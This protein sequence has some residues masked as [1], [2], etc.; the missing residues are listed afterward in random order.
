MNY[1]KPVSHEMKQNDG[2]QMW[3]RL[4]GVDWLVSYG[5]ENMKTKSWMVFDYDAGCEFF[6]TEEEAKD[7]AEALLDSYRED[8]CD[9]WDEG[10]EQ[11][12]VAKVTGKIS[13]PI[14]TEIKKGD[15]HYGGEFDF[16]R[17]YKFVTV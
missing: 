3:K 12:V 2:H 4:R 8:A 1:L 14:D 5:G 6:E 15:M 7:H 13:D 17:D 11:I 10:V 16:H 9:G